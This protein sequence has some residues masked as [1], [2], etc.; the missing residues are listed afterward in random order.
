MIVLIE[1]QAALVFAAFLD[2]HSVEVVATLEELDVLLVEFEVLGT[3]VAYVF[4]RGVA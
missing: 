3:L 4:V 2:A 1:A